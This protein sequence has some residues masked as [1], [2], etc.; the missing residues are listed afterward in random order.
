MSIHTQILV[1]L[2]N[3]R[4]VYMYM[5]MCVYPPTPADGKGERVREEITSSNCH[6]GPCFLFVQKATLGSATCRR[7]APSVLRFAGTL[8]LIWRDVRFAGL[9]AA[10]WTFLLVRSESNVR[11]CHVP[12]ASTFRPSLAC[13]FSV[14]GRPFCRPGS[15]ILDLASCSFRKQNLAVNGL[16]AAGPSFPAMV[17]WPC[18]TDASKLVAGSA[19]RQA[20]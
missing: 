3:R 2:W 5:Y 11:Q 8:F 7:P 12:A 16:P 4:S 18:R 14:A 10:F 13:C 9:A 19:G 1:S 20:D 17:L 15:C 6:F